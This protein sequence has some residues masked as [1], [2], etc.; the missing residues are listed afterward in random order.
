MKRI[1]AVAMATC[2]MLTGCMEMGLNAEINSDWSG[3]MKMSMK[4]KEAMFQMM[5]A[6]G[7]QT[8]ENMSFNEEAIRKETE[9]SGGKLKHFSSEV[10]GEWRHVQFEA[11]YP[12]IKESGDDAFSIKQEGDLWVWTMDMGDDTPMPTDP[13]EVEGM[14]AMM[15]GMMEGMKVELS[16][17]VPKLVETNLESKG[18]TVSYMF[19][20]NTMLKGKTGQEAVD[21]FKGL[22]GAKTIKFKLK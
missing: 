1:I 21:Q 15:G 5:E 3:T 12:D 18:N 17:T 6:Q 16:I 10:E 9:E 4:M 2:L 13:Q 11:W 20:Y 7:A 8:G 19:D 22:A 14:L